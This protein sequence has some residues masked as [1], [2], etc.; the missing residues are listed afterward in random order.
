MRLSYCLIALSAFLASSVRAIEELEIQLLHCTTISAT[1]QAESDSVDAVGSAGL[2]LHCRRKSSWTCEVRNS[3]KIVDPGASYATGSESPKALE[4]VSASDNSSI[5][6]DLDRKR[7]VFGA[8]ERD[9]WFTG[10]AATICRGG[11]TSI[12]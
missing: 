4:L 9:A 7:A 1:T 10:L 8:L 3:G 6:I 12:R 2:H 5:R 11:V